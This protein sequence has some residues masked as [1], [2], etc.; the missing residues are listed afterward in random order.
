M[1]SVA[2]LSVSSSASSQVEQFGAIVRLNRLPRRDATRRGGVSDVCPSEGDQAF[3]AA[4]VAPGDAIDGGVTDVPASGAARRVDVHLGIGDVGCHAEG[5]FYASVAD[6]ERRVVGAELVGLGE[7]EA[8]GRGAVSREED[9]RF[10]GESS[11]RE[12]KRPIGLQLD[13][14]VVVGAR[15]D[16]ADFDQRD[17]L[18]RLS[19]QQRQENCGG[20]DGPAPVAR[21]D[22]LPPFPWRL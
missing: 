20:R 22:H 14:A 17:R 8:V 15:V 3:A 21:L 19:E 16:L 1:K 2:L 18:G 13:I 12:R 7:G 11:A 10:P 6:Q 4:E 9:D 5:S